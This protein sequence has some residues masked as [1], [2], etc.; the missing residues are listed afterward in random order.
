ME[1]FGLPRDNQRND[2]GSP[3]TARDDYY[4]A[5]LKTVYDSA[6]A[7]SPIS[8]SNFWGWG[9]EGR[10]PNADYTW[11]VGDPF[12][13]DPPM[14][15]Q[16]LNSVFDVDSSTINIL[17]A[18][19]ALMIR[20]RQTTGIARDRIAYGFELYPNYPNPFNPSTRIKFSL[21]SSGRVILK[22]YDIMGKEI[23]TPVDEYKTAGMHETGFNGS[24]LP[25]GVYFYRLSVNECYSENKKMILMK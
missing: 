24:G 4:R 18:H 6:A 1:E 22:I 15:K 21:Q 25:S 20:L 17:K 2:I 23:M 12:V 11:R 19:S 5:L 9:G 14:E 13:C 7:G 10:S 8:G 3:T 16:G